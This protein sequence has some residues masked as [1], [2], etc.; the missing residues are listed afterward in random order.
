MAELGQYSQ[1][2]K[3]DSEKQEKKQ[4]K[5]EHAAKEHQHMDSRKA[6]SKAAKDSNATLTDRIKNGAQS[7]MDGA[8]E[9]KEGGNREYKDHKE[10]KAEQKRKEEEQER[11]RKEQEGLYMIL[12]FI[13]NYIV[14]NIL[15]FNLLASAHRSAEEKNMASRKEHF[16]AAMDSNS[17]LGDRAKAGMSAI[18]DG[19]KEMTEGFK[20]ERASSKASENN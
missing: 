17:T 14:T 9:L 8:K 6:H 5:V 4:E 1:S 18:S 20:R 15:L 3:H 10:D 16:N 11:L 2:N 13:S 19:F 7:C 12:F